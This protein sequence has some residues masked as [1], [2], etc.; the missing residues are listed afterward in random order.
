MSP[1]R[2]GPGGGGPSW[3][4]GDR[5]RGG[6]CVLVR[7][8]SSNPPTP[9]ENLIISLRSE[10]PELMTIKDMLFR[11]PKRH[12]IGRFPHDLFLAALITP[13]TGTQCKKNSYP[14]GSKI[15]S[16]VQL[17]FRAGNGYKTLHSNVFGFAPLKRD[18]CLTEGNIQMRHI[19]MIWGQKKKGESIQYW[20]G[21]AMLIH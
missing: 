17:L 11:P 4:A 13:Q 6:G 18:H 5:E 2:R 14:K 21:F 1:R 20:F 7:G 19:Q 12:T 10:S 9:H 15:Q 8:S 16:L 3:R